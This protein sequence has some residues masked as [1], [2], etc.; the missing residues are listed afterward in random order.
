MIKLT[1]VQKVSSLFLLMSLSL[2]PIA[3]IEYLLGFNYNSYILLADAYHTFIDAA[4]ALIVSVSLK[5]IINKRIKRIS[6][7]IYNIES[8]LILFASFIIVYFSID[9]LANSIRNLELEEIPYTLALI[10]W[11]SGILTLIIYLVER[12]YKWIGIVRTD[13]IHSK[14]DMMSEILTGVVIIVSNPFLTTIAT[15]LIV[16]FLLVDVIKEVKEALYSIIG[17]TV[18]SPLKEKVIKILLSRGFSVL[19]VKFRRLGSFMVVSVVI[20]LPSDIAL[21]RAYRIKKEVKRI[22]YRLENIVIVEVTL[23]PSRKMKLE[24]VEAVSSIV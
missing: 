22:L 9:L 5:I 24:S 12:K 15:F 16:S 21:A 20:A 14:L 13:M 3:I 1:E 18:N 2:F 10:P 19:D 6:N 7:E 4:F 8:L 11:I 23:V 17:I